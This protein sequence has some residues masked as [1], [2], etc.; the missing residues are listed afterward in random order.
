MLWVDIVLAVV[1]LGIEL[2]VCLMLGFIPNKYLEDLM[3]ALAIALSIVFPIAYLS[4]EYRTAL[5]IDANMLIVAGVALFL[6]LFG[7]LA[8]TELKEN[9][10]QRRRKTKISKMW[11]EGR[12]AAR[13]VS[14]E[15]TRSAEERLE[16]FRKEN[17]DLYEQIRE[18]LLYQELDD[19][20]RWQDIVRK[21]F[22]SQLKVEFSDFLAE[23]GIVYNFLHILNG[24]IR[25][26]IVF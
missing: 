26:L 8:G 5:A 4:L 14:E 20:V 19:L 3:C 12:E 11:S 24:L 21:M 17:A 7:L 15:D 6:P 25:K 13:D 9:V 22:L 16:E 18:K 10:R 2:V 1:V 23:L